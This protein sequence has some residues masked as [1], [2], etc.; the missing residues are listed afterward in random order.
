M[1]LI[2]LGSIHDSR[3]DILQI[4]FRCIKEGAH[5]VFVTRKLNPMVVTHRLRLFGGYSIKNCSTQTETQAPVDDNKDEGSSVDEIRFTQNPT[6]NESHQYGNLSES[7]NSSRGLEDDGKQHS[8]NERPEK[9][10]TVVQPSDDELTIKTKDR[11]WKRAS[12]SAFD[13]SQVRDLVS[14]KGM[15]VLKIAKIA[16]KYTET[17][18]EPYDSDIE[19]ITPSCLVGLVKERKEK[20]NAALKKYKEKRDSKFPKKPLNSAKNSQGKKV[21]VPRLKASPV[22]K[23]GNRNVWLTQTA[24]NNIVNLPGRKTFAYHDKNVL[25]RDVLLDKESQVSKGK[26]VARAVFVYFGIPFERTNVRLGI[27][28]MKTSLLD[29]NIQVLDGYSFYCF[30]KELMG[31]CLPYN[32]FVRQ[33]AHPF[34]KFCARKGKMRLSVGDEVF[35]RSIR[36]EEK[37]LKEQGL[38][39]FP[40]IKELKLKFNEFIDKEAKRG[41]KEKIMKQEADT[42]DL[43]EAAEDADNTEVTGVKEYRERAGIS[44][45]LTE[46]SSS[47]DSEDHKDS[48]GDS[49]SEG[50]IQSEE[51]SGINHRK[52]SYLGYDLDDMVVSDTESIEYQEGAF[53]A[54]NGDMEI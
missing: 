53:D 21:K 3:D 16:E 36:R 9:T 4:V 30:W 31:G 28:R 54:D 20:I 47:E 15:N 12:L 5:R 23:L 33:I 10:E 32:V 48:T 26:A 13:R 6:L 39:S 35:L 22:K 38:E 7:E 25:M 42:L 27:K 18:A 50:S 43:I 8:K 51:K 14:V 45:G 24:K 44:T 11:L 49:E 29:P 19:E 46:S 52:K 40:I 1:K 2:Y 34:N 37:K 41:K 17:Q